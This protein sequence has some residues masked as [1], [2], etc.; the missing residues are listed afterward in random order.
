MKSRKAEDFT[1]YYQKKKVTGTYDSQKRGKFLIVEEKDI[2]NLN[3][4]LNF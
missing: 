2:S 1:E 4:F 3:I